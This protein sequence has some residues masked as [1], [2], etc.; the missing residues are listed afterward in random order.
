MKQLITLLSVMVLTGC[1]SD[2]EEYDGVT[3][4]WTPR[5]INQVFTF[6]SSGKTPS[7]MPTG[8]DDYSRGV[9]D[10]CNTYTGIIGNG[11]LQW[12]GHYADPQ[13]IQESDDYYE[14]YRMGANYCTYHLDPE[15][16]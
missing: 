2:V 15:P 11:M 6:G 1:V 13:S 5:S 3:G 12:H 8:S 9:R 4:T 7:G 10:G 14:G 16:L